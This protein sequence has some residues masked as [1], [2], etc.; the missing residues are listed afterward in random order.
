MSPYS[1][2]SAA[3]VAD[4]DVLKCYGLCYDR[5][6]GYDTMEICISKQSA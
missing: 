5:L 6:S 2:N 3:E 1:R 4:Q